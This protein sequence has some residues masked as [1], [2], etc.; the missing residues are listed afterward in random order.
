M[1]WPFCVEFGCMNRCC[2]ALNSV[3]CWPHTQH[4]ATRA[5]EARHPRAEGPDYCE[6]DDSPASASNRQGKQ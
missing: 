4:L 6:P 1:D 3:Y 2:L 5:V